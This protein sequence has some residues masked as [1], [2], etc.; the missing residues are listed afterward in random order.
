MRFQ[1]GLSQTI[2][3]KL[4]NYFDS[5]DIGYWFIQLLIIPVVVV[6]AFLVVEILGEHALARISGEYWGWGADLLL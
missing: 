3:R 4:I 2:L 1:A 5:T 6:H